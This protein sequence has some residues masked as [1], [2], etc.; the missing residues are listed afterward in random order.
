MP[1]Y[2]SAIKFLQT[3]LTAEVAKISVATSE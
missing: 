3:L 1:V 2:S